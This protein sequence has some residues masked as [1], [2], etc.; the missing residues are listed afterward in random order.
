MLHTFC[1]TGGLIVLTDCQFERE[2][3][4]LG[5]AYETEAI[6]LLAAGSTTCGQAAIVHMTS[7]SLNA[8]GTCL[9][10]ATIL[11]HRLCTFG[12]MV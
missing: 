5:Y 1:L 10:Q 8:L 6:E 12:A 9:D 2:L 4:C 3:R 11:N 7:L